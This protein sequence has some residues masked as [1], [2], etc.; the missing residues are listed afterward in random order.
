[1]QIAMDQARFDLL[2]EKLK[3]SQGIQLTGPEGTIEKMGVKASYLFDGK[4]LTVEVLEKPMIVSKEYVEK[5][6]KEWLG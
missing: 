2:T 4:M 3:S 5:Q 1:M 6:F